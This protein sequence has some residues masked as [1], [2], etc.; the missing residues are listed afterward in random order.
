[1]SLAALLFALAPT[2]PVAPRLP[3]PPTPLHRMVAQS[4]L[5]AVVRPGPTVSSR[6]LEDD[7]APDGRV[8]LFLRE[9][10]AGDAEGGH[11]T[12]CCDTR[13]VCPTPAR[14]PEGEDVL[15]FLTRSP[16]GWCAVGGPLGGNDAI[17]R[18]EAADLPVWRARIRE[19]RALVC[20][21]GERWLDSPEVVEWL[22]RCAEEPATRLAGAGALWLLEREPAGPRLHP[23]QRRRLADVLVASPELGP[24]EDRLLELL[25]DFPS[26]ALD[27]RVLAWARDLARRGDGLAC[28]LV[29]LLARRWD[30]PEAARR[31]RH[32]SD[33]WLGGQGTMAAG[34]LLRRIDDVAA[35]APR[36]G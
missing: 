14:Y 30:D 35:L 3:T 33:D 2:G 15:V 20:S 16:W 26:A 10:I 4:A 8:T 22:V 24:G 25:A 13:V 12:A 1:M 5:I 28:H 23:L 31:A 32:L 6:V 27:A 19:L 36:G 18:V 17:K 11:V 21:L 9:V 34:E 29:E 7:Y